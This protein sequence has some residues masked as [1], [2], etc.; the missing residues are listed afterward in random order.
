VYAHSD[1]WIVLA[2]LT[3]PCVLLTVIDA[4]VLAWLITRRRR[5]QVAPVGVP[6]WS[7]SQIR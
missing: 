3:V 2:A 5:D 7:S 4:V 1:L 6:K